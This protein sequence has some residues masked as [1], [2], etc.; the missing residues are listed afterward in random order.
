ML[1][2]SS[3]SN[4]FNIPL[5]TKKQKKIDFFFESHGYK[6]YQLVIFIIFFLVLFSDSLQILLMTLILKT[7]KD[8]WKL[9]ETAKSFLM[10]SIFM[11]MVIGSFFIS[12]YLDMF[13]RKIFLFIGSLILLIF[14]IMS[15][16]SNS[17][18]ELLIF[19]LL[20]GIGIGIQMPSGMNLASE[21]IPS[22]NRSIFLSSVWL[23]FPIGEIYCCLS[24][25]ILMP[26]FETGKWR[27][28]IFVCCVPIIILL[29]F[30]KYIH[31]SARFLYAHH[32]FEEGKEVLKRIEE[33]NKIKEEDRLVEED[34]VL[35]EKET[36]E[37]ILNSYNSEIKELFNNRYFYTTLKTWVLW[38]SG[39]IGLYLTIYLI[40]QVL[41]RIENNIVSSHNTIDYNKFY[42]N[43]LISSLIAM[44]KAF[45]AG[46][47]AE[48]YG[49]INSMVLLQ[50]LA[51]LFCILILITD[52]YFSLLS[53]L[54]KLVSGG[55]IM[56]IKVYSTEVYPTKLRGIGSSFGHSVGRLLIVFIPFISQLF[57]YLTNSD[58]SPF[59]F[60]FLISAIGIYCAY[61]L[62]F[63]TMGRELDLPDKDDYFQ[64]SE[65]NEKK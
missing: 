56:N 39:D 19:R 41:I 29:L 44:P 31:E 22:Y 13:G 7:I 20:I 32:R 34:F 14:S 24:A 50:S 58:K 33:F 60:I 9:S 21:N 6:H 63:E 45:I 1:T 65:L 36:K 53:G 18:L 10:S 64:L 55:V 52:S 16:F 28:L 46:V 61:T 43:L 17:F 11:G 27:S 12:K 26:H 54:I 51:C 30:G 47:I 37:N 35:I 42:I 59:L 2:N 40:P 4:D 62:P 49:R 15:S 3:S 5:N 38:C 25:W 23:A 48:Y 8:E 57:Q